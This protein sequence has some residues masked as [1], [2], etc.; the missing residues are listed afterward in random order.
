MDEGPN[1]PNA[2][3]RDKAVSNLL[4]ALGWFGL[5]VGVAE[6]FI[7]YFIYG[8][9]IWSPTACVVATVTGLLLHGA[10]YAWPPS[11][12][13]TRAFLLRV[14]LPLVRRRR[15]LAVLGVLTLWTILLFQIASVRSDLDMYAM[16]RQLTRQQARNLTA[17]LSAHGPYAVVVRANPSDSESREY[18]S[19][20]YSALYQSGWTVDFDLSDN[21]PKPAEGLTIQVIG[22]NSRPND[23]KNDPAATLRNAFQ[24]ADLPSG[25]G[26]TGAGAYKL[27]VMVGHRPVAIGKQSPFPIWVGEWME[28]SSIRLFRWWNGV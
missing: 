10:A 17:Y 3:R 26:A 5:Y 4:H 21:D 16:P 7:Q 8:G 13:K 25:G 20:I 14:F 27:F 22:A 6:P 1:D 19:A 24:A 15:T 12:P 2:S 11:K 18:A 28:R 9:N 23:P